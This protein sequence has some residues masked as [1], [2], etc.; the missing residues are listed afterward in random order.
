[1]P[2]DDR[3]L[4][5]WRRRRAAYYGVLAV[6]FA[7]VAFFVGPNLLLFGKPT[8]LTPADFVPTVEERC[9]PIVRA[10]K[11]FQRDHGRLPDRGA[12]LM[13]H[14]HPQEDPSVQY[15][16][17]SVHRGRFDRWAAY[18][19]NITYDFNPVTEG[20]YVS[21]AFAHGRIPLPPVKI[22]PRP[23]AASGPSTEPASGPTSGP[24]G[25]TR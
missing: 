18:N 7:A 15:V 16:S 10:M 25:R 12:E 13:P 19:H 20:W 3:Y 23:G 8:G 6:V 24:A 17:A 2:A 4:K 21:G 11:E 9:V 1:M 22:D 5:R 14:Y